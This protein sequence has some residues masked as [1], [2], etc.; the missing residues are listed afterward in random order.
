MS[1][2]T[3]CSEC[4]KQYRFSDDRAGRTVRCKDCGVDIEIPTKRRKGGSKK[5]KN[6]SLVPGVLIGGVVAGVER[7][8]FVAVVRRDA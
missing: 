3:E 8:R 6:S 5:R 2:E 4:G 1:I 7:V